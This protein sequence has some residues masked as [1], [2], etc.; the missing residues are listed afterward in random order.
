MF[1]DL[2]SKIENWKF[3]N[4]LYDERDD[5]PFSMARKTHRTSDI[6]SEMFYSISGA[7]M[8]RTAGTTRKYDKS[9]DVI[10]AMSK[11]G[12]NIFLFV[13]SMAEIDIRHFLS[14]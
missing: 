8:L 11:Q 2:V 3:N 12:G 1:L 13:R 7:E 5:F 14:K 6:P 10:Y 4:Q 9:V